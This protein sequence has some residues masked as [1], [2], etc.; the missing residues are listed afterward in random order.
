VSNNDNFSTSLV[1]LV[2]CLYCTMPL[3]GQWL[4]HNGK[5]EAHGLCGL[6]DHITRSEAP[7]L[8]YN[9]L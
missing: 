5:M 3:Y 7:E 2:L 8:N 1:V 4:L 9:T 6:E